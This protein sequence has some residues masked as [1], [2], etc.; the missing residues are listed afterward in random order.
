M[1]IQSLKSSDINRLCSQQVVI[2]LENALKE[3]IENSIDA[4]STSIEINFKKSGFDLIEVT[5]NGCGIEEEDFQNVA[6]HHATS[7]IE[8]FDDL[9]SDEFLGEDESM[10]LGFRGEALAA[11]VNISQKVVVFTKSIKG[12]NPGP[13]GHKLHFNINGQLINTMK[14]PKSSSGTQ[15]SI[16]KLFDKLPVR[17]KQLEKHLKSEY[18]KALKLIQN[19]AIYYFKIKFVVKNDGKNVQSIPI[20]KNWLARVN[21]V[22]PNL[23]SSNFIEINDTNGITGLISKPGNGHPAENGPLKHIFINH[24]PV[25]INKFEKLISEL[26][27]SEGGWRHLYP[28]YCLN[29]QIDQSKLDINCT[30]DKRSIFI[31]QSSVVEKKLSEVLKK[32]WNIE[33]RSV[34][35]TDDGLKEFLERQRKKEEIV[36]KEKEEVSDQPE[37][38]QPLFVAA[39]SLIP[40]MGTEQAELGPEPES[41]LSEKEPSPE[42]TPH[43]C[44]FLTASEIHVPQCSKSEK[45]KHPESTSIAP[46][47]PE[48]ND[49][50]Q[51]DQI[52]KNLTKTDFSKMKVI[53]QFNK[54]FIITKLENNLFL[55]DQ[56]A[57][58]EITR[59][60]KFTKSCKLKTQILTV[61][62]NLNLSEVEIEYFKENAE[63]FIKNKFK[64]NDDFTKLTTLPTF[65]DYQ[66]DVNDFRELLSIVMNDNMPRQFI[67]E[68]KPRK[69]R[70]R[71]AYKACRTAVMAGDALETKVMEQV[72][73]GL[74]VLEK[75]WN[76]PHGRPTCRH[77]TTVDECDNQND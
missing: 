17:R 14:S 42:V 66:L 6:K 5:D 58:D 29:I 43:K 55:I 10:T 25:I 73:R 49:D 33:E 48:L 23:K 13:L 69:I 28:L 47:M 19:Y 40:K 56:H 51:P 68:L 20:S 15:V 71:L 74:A 22:F 62:I 30:P 75:P 70:K 39:S 32:C 34:G 3:L 46:K 76:C 7:K 64:P 41:N 27:K 4:K 36:K 26:W 11:L 35:S 12:K 54:S 9:A 45:R 50:Y 8:S 2:T 31:N 65:E 21:L 1:P 37:P 38:T 60:E 63:M 24:R 18:K 72:V 16:T 44:H 57:A 61:P 77:L 67:D 59:F 52:T 53:G